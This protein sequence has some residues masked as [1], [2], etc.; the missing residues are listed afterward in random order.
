M[1]TSEGAAANFRELND[2]ELARLARDSEERLVAYIV[3]ARAAGRLEAAVHGAQVLAFSYQERI[4]GFVFTKIG[5]RGTVVADEI[6]E[7]TVADAISSLEGFAGSTIP[8]LRSWIF[9]IARRR[10]ADYLRRGRVQEEP[11][12]IDWGEGGQE[13]E[14]MRTTDPF[15]AV[16]RGSIFNLGST[17]LVPSP[18]KASSSFASREAWRSR[19]TAAGSAVT[20]L[21]ASSSEVGPRGYRSPCPDRRRGRPRRGRSGGRSRGPPIVA[22][23]WSHL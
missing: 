21:L 12:E 22:V 5:G 1:G 20:P 15:D 8:E 16:D 2:V 4:R 18:R 10:I 19:S 3:E 9:T 6:A 11:L 17:G 7:R 23:R 14:E 13:R